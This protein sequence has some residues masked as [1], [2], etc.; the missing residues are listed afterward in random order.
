[1]QAILASRC[2]QCH[3]DGGVEAKE[4][5]F[6]TYAHVYAQRTSILTQVAPCKMPPQDGTA[7]SQLTL[8]EREAL[9]GWLVCRA[10]EN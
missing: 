7:L 6:D 9:L 4:H 2:G 5:N 1:M 8:E 10:P 3:E